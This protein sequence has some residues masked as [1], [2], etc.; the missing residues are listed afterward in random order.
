MFT[1]AIMSRNGSSHREIPAYDSATADSIACREAA[2]LKRTHIVVLHDGD[3]WRRVMPAGAY[4]AMT[5]AQI[6]NLGL[7]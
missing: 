1:I 5:T 7:N 2:A 4:R 6:Q 3:A